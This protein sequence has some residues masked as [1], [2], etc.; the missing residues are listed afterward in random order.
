M[1][2][3]K[4]AFT[5]D[6]WS[7]PLLVLYYINVLGGLSIVSKSIDNC[8]ANAAYIEEAQDNEPNYTSHLSKSLQRRPKSDVMVYYWQQ[9]STDW[10]I[11]NWHTTSVCL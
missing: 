4:A 2:K 8:K 10:L 9:Y 11:Q 1:P 7:L 3:N 5:H 6:L